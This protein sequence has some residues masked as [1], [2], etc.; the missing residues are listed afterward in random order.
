M[1]LLQ[2]NAYLDE[3]ASTYPFVNSVSIGE[4]YEGRD[5]RVLQIMKAGEGKPNVFIEAGN[6]L[7]H[8]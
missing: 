7:K 5:M 1:I 2:I 3:L 4:T 6:L 8:F